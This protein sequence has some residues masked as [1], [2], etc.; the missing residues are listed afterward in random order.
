MDVARMT[1]SATHV[2]DV[3]DW[4]TYYNKTPATKSVASKCE[5]SVG[6]VNSTKHTV[7]VTPPD[8]VGVVE[9]SKNNTPDM[10]DIELVSPVQGA[11]QQ[12]RAELERA[13]PIKSLNVV[14]KRH[15]KSSGH[16]QRSK[17]KKKKKKKKKKKQKKKKKKKK[18]TKR[19]KSKIHKKKTK[20]KKKRRQS[21]KKTRDIFSL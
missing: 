19:L 18:V 9:Q 15:R 4:I 21:K 7:V 16:K 12:A 3:Q 10:Q 13:E 5:E 8:I 11:V 17:G 1:N 2:F 6:G 20:L 14:K